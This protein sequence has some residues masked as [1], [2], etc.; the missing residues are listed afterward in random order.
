V[1][2]EDL[3]TGGGRETFTPTYTV[4]GSGTMGAR[5]IVDN[6]RSDWL[7]LKLVDR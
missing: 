5:C 2:P 1:G 6:V 7:F 3:L 4:Q